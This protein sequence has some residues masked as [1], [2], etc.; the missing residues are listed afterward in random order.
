M[1]L[2]QQLS[3]WESPERMTF[4]DEII[5]TTEQAVAE[6]QEARP[7][8]Q[9]KQQLSDRPDRRLFRRAL[10]TPGTSLI[11]EFKRHWPSMQTE[12]DDMR[13]AE[14]VEAYVEGGAGAISVLTEADH[15]FGSLDDLRTTR[16][17]CDLPVLRKDF[18]VGEYQVYEA[19]EAGADAVLLIVALLRRRDDALARLYQLARSLGLDVLMEAR[20]I[21]ELELAL[22]IGTDIVGINNRDLNKPHDVKLAATRE[23]VSRIPD[24]VIKVSESGLSSAQDLEELADLGVNGALV[25]TA[26]MMASDRVR[27]CRDLVHAGR[28]RAERRPP[29]AA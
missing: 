2:R 28:R 9:I 12:P 25:G 8:G 27:H 1:L 23:L 18:I 13:L 15:F 6:R 5:Q 14:T 17:I 4:L 22:E 7:L 19:A 3:E 11:A 20:D 21:D 24:D 29:V 10:E 16:S 26:L